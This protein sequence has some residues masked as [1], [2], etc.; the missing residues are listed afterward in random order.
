[1]E[2]SI[3]FT[4]KYKFLNQRDKKADDEMASRFRMISFLNLLKDI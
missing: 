4:A 3:E 1:M 2:T